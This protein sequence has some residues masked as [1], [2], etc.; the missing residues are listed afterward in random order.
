[1]VNHTFATR[2]WPAGG[3]VGQRLKQGWADSPTPWRE[4]VGVVSDVKTHG[5]AEATPLQVYSPLAQDTVRSVALIVRTSIAPEAVLLSLSDLVKTLNGDL[6]VYNAAT[7]KSML[8]E[9]TARERVTATVLGVFAVIALLLAAIGLF[10]VVSH[11]VTER[12][13][14]IG[15]RLALGASPAGIIRLFLKAGVATAATGIAI[16]AAGS[17]W[18]TRFLSQLLFGVTPVDGL[19]FAAA[20]GV[21][22]GVAVVACYVPA[23]RAARISPTIALR[24]E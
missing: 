10:G 6:P 23:V 14:E 22:F 7:L 21:L 9:S 17:F 5:V 1:V 20:A 4:I 24:G 15:V 19:A 2:F 11:G 8:A 12:T 13:P 16:G 18:L 3:A